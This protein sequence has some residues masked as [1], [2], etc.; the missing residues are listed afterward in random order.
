MTAFPPSL[1]DLSVMLDK[2]VPYAAV[3]DVLKNTPLPVGLHFDLIDLYE[4]GRL[5]QGKKSVTFT[6]A[7]SAPDRTLKDAETDAAF[8]ALLENLKAKTGAELR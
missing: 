5:P 6:L 3:A 8:N 2:T 7:F 1:R 4:G